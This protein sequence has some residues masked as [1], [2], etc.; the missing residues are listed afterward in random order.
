DISG[1]GQTQAAHDLCA[2]IPA[3]KKMDYVQA[4]VGH[5]GVFNGRRWKSEI[6]P[7]VSD[8]IRTHP[9]AD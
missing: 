3:S 4:G 9:I 2:N 1:I 8:F 6:A 7:R 5:Y